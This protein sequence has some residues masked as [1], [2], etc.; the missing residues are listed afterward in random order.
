[1]NGERFASI[2]LVLAVTGCSAIFDMSNYDDGRASSSNATKA[3]GGGVVD[4]SD[5][6]EGNEDGGASSSGSAND[7]QAST[8]ADSST[9]GGCAKEGEPN[10]SAVDAH[11]L[12]IGQTC[13][14]LSSTGDE[15][16]FTFTTGA[17]STIELALTSALHA[18]LDE[19]STGTVHSSIGGGFTS[20][21][22]PAGE[23]IVHV[24]Y[25]GNEGALGYTITRK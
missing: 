9:A 1:M 3:D 2:A 20:K 18:D 16:F 11:V 14:V 24:T 21:Q 12:P 13:A 7:A 6:V 19:V 22:L 25:S 5:S 15:D 8:D 4:G 17:P 10:D 23:Y